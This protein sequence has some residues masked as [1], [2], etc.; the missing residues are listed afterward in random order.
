MIKDNV[1]AM[2]EYWSVLIFI[3]IGLQLPFR[4]P[5]NYFVIYSVIS[6]I[7]LGIC[8]ELTAEF[9]AWM[10]ILFIEGISVFLLFQGKW[11]ERLFAFYLS[12]LS[13]SIVSGWITGLVAL[14]YKP[15]VLVNDSFLLQS[16]V[17]IVFLVLVII[18]DRYR[19]PSQG[20]EH[21]KK[22]WCTVPVFLV[23]TI[24]CIASHMGLTMLLGN[25]YDEGGDFPKTMIFITMAVE[26]VFILIAVFLWLSQQK[27][28]QLQR[29][30]FQ[31][32]QYIQ[33]RE[34]QYR[35]LEQNE[36]VIRT[37]KHD[38]DTH[39]DC[40]HTLLNK[41]CVQEANQYIE[42]II[43]VKEHTIPRLFK[44]GNL[45]M[46]ILLAE[47]QEHLASQVVLFEVN[48][49]FPEE[50][51][52]EAYDM[53]TLFGNLFH[54]AAEAVNR[55]PA[56][57]EKAIHISF[58]K[59]GRYLMCIVDNTYMQ[60]LKQ[61]RKGNYLTTKENEEKQHGYGIRNAKRIVKHYNG[62]IWF[63]PEAGHFKVEVMLPV[64]K[65]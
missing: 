21:C 14:S 1:C 55:M 47:L 61:D 38:M 59:E 16:I 53:T 35:F 36:K 7:I 31:K 10:G 65:E 44:S 60:E 27:K 25:Y 13:F 52:I 4:K 42:K 28:K 58:H 57:A 29:D 63:H 34:Q 26:F 50:V 2:L 20:L 8:S 15:D 51:N 17:C 33:L 22:E 40:I 23:V 49:K 19:I 11:Q 56:D 6:I 18:Y 30:N 9:Q 54:N 24:T 12:Y 45:Y 64:V 46:D 37:L 41:G 39:L 3:R 48:G 43:Q 5:R 62:E 32:E